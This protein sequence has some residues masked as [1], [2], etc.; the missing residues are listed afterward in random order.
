MHTHGHVIEFHTR[1]YVTVID[2][3]ERTDNV[4]YSSKV[5]RRLLLKTAVVALIRERSSTER[6]QTEKPHVS[7]DI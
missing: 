2:A 6:G 3:N 1:R 5:T 4:N 7:S